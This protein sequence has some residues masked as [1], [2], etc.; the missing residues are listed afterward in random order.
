[1]D[2]SAELLA[3]GSAAAWVLYKLDG[4]LDHVL[5]DPVHRHGSFGTV[6]EQIVQQNL[7]RQH[8]QKRKE[9]RRAR[10]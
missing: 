2:F 8:R 1:M 7:N 5:V 6:I 3:D 4:G 9:H 10:H